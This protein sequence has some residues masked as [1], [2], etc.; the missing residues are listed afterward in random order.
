[1]RSWACVLLT[2][3]R[4]TASGCRPAALAARASS[5]RM[6]VR[7]RATAVA[8]MHVPFLMS[9]PFLVIR[10]CDLGATAW[11]A[12]RGAA[13][14]AA[15][16]KRAKAL[17]NGR[18]RLLAAGGAGCVGAATVGANDTHRR[19]W[20]LV[21]AGRIKDNPGRGGQ[22]SCP[23][24]LGAPE[25][26]SACSLNRN[27]GVY[28]MKK[29]LL[30]TT[31][32]IAA[33]AIAGAAMVATPAAAQMQG[34]IS[35]GG[36]LD[37]SF[38]GRNDFAWVY[39]DDDLTTGRE[40]TFF[41]DF[42]LQ[43]SADGVG[44]ATGIRYGYRNRLRTS[45]GNVN[46]DRNW[47][48]FRGGFGEVRMG[49]EDPITNTLRISGSSFTAKG[50]G[51]IDGFSNA[52]PRV[53]IQD[54]GNASKVIYLTP[55]VM[56]FQAGIDYAVQDGST[57]RGSLQAPGAGHQDPWSVG[58]NWQGNFA[59]A[60]L[61]VYVGYAGSSGTTGLEGRRNLQTG[62]RAGFMGFDVDFGYG[63]ERSSANPGLTPRVNFFNAGIGTEIGGVGLSFTFQNDNNKFT[64]A[65][66]YYYFSAGT[67]ILPGVQ[68]LG[69]IGYVDG[70]ADGIDAI[71]KVRT[72]F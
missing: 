3:M 54:S 15:S 31:G 6:S 21:A 18:F 44:D 19:L 28:I 34:A 8:S 25:W 55:N 14:G 67:P 60:D 4:V 71:V 10:P 59:G 50:T 32:L 48:F 61:G 26:V 16:S 47:V 66:Q 69:D 23:D 65:T 57:G 62:F 43:F 41:N 5:P 2:A 58:G 45:N 22:G 72:S 9:W 11:E 12:P 64:D 39:T 30:G 33:G 51:G 36:A 63:E 1:M 53:R 35:T 38:S 46:F 68:L 24:R 52:I 56:G 49:V 37:L 70:A 13:R 40:S 7:F 42:R 20:S 27:D 29:V 17:W